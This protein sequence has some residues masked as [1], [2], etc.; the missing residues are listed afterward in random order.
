MYLVGAYARVFRGRQRNH[1]SDFVGRSQDCEGNFE[2]SMGLKSR[3]ADVNPTLNGVE[4]L[5][6]D[7]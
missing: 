5:Q 3:E 7:E 1:I 4:R 6:P 2:R